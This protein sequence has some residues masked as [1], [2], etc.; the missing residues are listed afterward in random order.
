MTLPV[1]IL[2]GGLATRLRP[3]T[4]KIPKGLVDVAGKPFIQHQLELLRRHGFSRVVLCVGYLGEMVR[5]VFGDGS[6]WGMDIEYVFDGDPLLGT[7]GA[8]R[9][10][11][12][13]LGEQF[14]ILYGDTYL[15]CDYAAVEKSFVVSGKKGLMTVFQNCNRWDQSN[16]LFSRDQIRCYDKHDPTPDMQHID[17]GLGVLQ[18]KVFDAYPQDT[19]I[20]LATIY[21]DLV[22]QEQL[23]G[24]EVIKRFYEIGTPAGLE[25]T[26]NYFTEKRKWIT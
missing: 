12:P 21:Q 26:R 13:L 6:E 24:F 19:V 18:S 23:A 11:L 9:K 4:Q 20:D 25:E 2:A 10:A 17:Y 8:L 16:V 3:I 15:D 1:A 22:T 5:D 14:L 7:G